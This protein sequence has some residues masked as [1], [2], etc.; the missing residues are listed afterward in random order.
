M[1]GSGFFPSHL[2]RTS[3]HCRDEFGTGSGFRAL[4]LD[5]KSLN[6]S[7]AMPHLGSYDGH[8]CET[9]P[10]SSASLAAKG[11]RCSLGGGTPDKVLVSIIL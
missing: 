5:P 7:E 8:L 9:H 1:E 11:I 2:A 3:P 4:G 6:G 10:G